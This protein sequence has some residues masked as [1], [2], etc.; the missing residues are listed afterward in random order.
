M[1]VTMDVLHLHALL[2][3]HVLLLLLLADVMVLGGSESLVA[4]DVLL[5]K[6]IIRRRPWST[7]NHEPVL[8]P[9]TLSEGA[10][11]VLLQELVRVEVLACCLAPR[12]EEQ[13]VS[14]QC[15]RI[16][17]GAKAIYDH[18]EGLAEFVD[19][20]TESDALLA[21]VNEDLSKASASQ[22]K[23]EYCC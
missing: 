13:V 21:S 9:V 23:A 11:P 1:L 4:R 20:R 14:H 15:S 12:H 22:V 2:G 18:S 16:E 3:V 8:E 10:I 5:L 17:R 19:G 7:E 6:T